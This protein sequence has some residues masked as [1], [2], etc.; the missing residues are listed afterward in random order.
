VRC[1]KFGASAAGQTEFVEMSLFDP[2]YVEAMTAC[3]SARSAVQQMLD[4]YSN[5]CR[6]RSAS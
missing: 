6:F 4:G 1:E 5:D 3:F 2:A